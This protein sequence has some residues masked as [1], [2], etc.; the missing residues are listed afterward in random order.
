MRILG[1]ILIV[2][3]A[4]GL[5]F[6]AIPY[7]EKQKVFEVGSLSAQTEQHKELEIP[8]VVSGV[9]LGA[10]VVL[11]LLSGRRRS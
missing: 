11:L 5:A 1:I 10:G 8:P 9:V 6:K 2:L 4:L 3:G 7:T